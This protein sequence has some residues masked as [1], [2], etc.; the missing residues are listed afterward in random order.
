MQSCEPNGIRLSRQSRPFPAQQDAILTPH[1]QPE[2]AV[3]VKEPWHQIM[4]GS[5]TAFALE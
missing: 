2:T 3:D 5:V 4:T 1:N